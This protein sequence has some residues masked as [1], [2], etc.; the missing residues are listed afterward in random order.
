M[1]VATLFNTSVP[2]YESQSIRVYN[3]DVDG[4]SNVNDI[5]T[6][7][8]TLT[9]GVGSVTLS[10][11]N[12]SDLLVS[13]PV[14][15]NDLRLINTGNVLLTTDATSNLIVNNTIVSS[16]IEFTDN[17]SPQ[18]PLS[19]YN[20]I[21][22]DTAIPLDYLGSP[23]GELFCRW[24]RIGN[25]FFCEA[26]GYLNFPVGSVLSTVAFPSQ[27]RPSHQVTFG[28]PF[29]QLS[30]TPAFLIAFCTLGTNG[31][32]TITTAAPTAG[33]GTYYTGLTTAPTN[34][35]RYTFSYRF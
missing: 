28:L 8:I 20:T 6:N 5:S 31:I 16:A 18:T 30:G 33:A 1:S 11:D 27:F 3:L 2:A 10:T 9:N 19:I 12:A 21:I 15:T 22:T 14:V 17:L 24:E 7:E 32:I 26:R 35:D 25:I 13:G 34:Y 23:V 29:Y 4:T